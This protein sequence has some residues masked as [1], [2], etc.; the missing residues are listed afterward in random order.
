MPRSSECGSIATTRQSTPSTRRRPASMSYSESKTVAERA[1]RDVASSLGV[2]IVTVHPSFVQ[3]WLLFHIHAGVHTPRVAAQGPMLLPRVPT[4]ADVLKQ[5]LEGA[6][7]AVPP[8]GMNWRDVRDVADVHV[9][10]RRAPRG[11]RV[12]CAPTHDL[13][14]AVSRRYQR[15][16]SHTPTP[17]AAVTLSTRDQCCSPRWRT[18]CARA[19]PSGA[20]PSGA[21]RGRSC[22]SPLSL[23]RR[24][25][26]T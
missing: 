17:S 18:R 13:P 19:F 1:A 14:S 2:E 6:V 7:P 22:T 11:C 4:S 16:R 3:A 15:R 23:T 5:L 24:N 26:P 12:V 8:V 25:A 21:R 20:C 9:E 10:A